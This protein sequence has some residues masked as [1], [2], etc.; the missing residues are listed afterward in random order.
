MTREEWHIILERDATYDGNELLNAAR[1]NRLWGAIDRRALIGVVR[2]MARLLKYPYAYSSAK[3]LM[4]DGWRDDVR[5]ALAPFDEQP[6][7]AEEHP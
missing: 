2:E 3:V 4:P 6:D 5:S 7:K 1:M